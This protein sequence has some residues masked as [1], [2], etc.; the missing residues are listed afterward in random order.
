MLS[1]SRIMLSSCR[2]VILQADLCAPDPSLCLSLLYSSI[3][4][5]WASVLIYTD[6]EYQVKYHTDYN[7]N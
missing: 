5:S 2:T 4:Y 3:M 1:E 7:N 6:I